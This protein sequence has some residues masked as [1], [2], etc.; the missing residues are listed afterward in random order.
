M[1]LWTEIQL[2]RNVLLCEVV[3]IF[4]MFFKK[5]AKKH[6]ANIALKMKFFHFFARTVLNKI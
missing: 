4:I 6:F 5:V 1:F 2:G 3:I